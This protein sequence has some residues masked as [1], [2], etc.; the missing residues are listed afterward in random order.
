MTTDKVQL[1]T[2]E[3]LEQFAESILKLRLLYRVQITDIAPARLGVVFTFTT[4]E[5]RH[6]L[7]DIMSHAFGN[8]VI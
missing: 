3:Q 7:R 2:M 1:V 8:S 6:S 4:Y 5:H